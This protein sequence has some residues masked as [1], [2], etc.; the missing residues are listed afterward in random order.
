MKTLKNRALEI[1]N[2]TTYKANT[3]F[4]VGAT[5]FTLNVNDVPGTD[6]NFEWRVVI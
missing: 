3:A 4:R 5:T 2:E 1:R 6:I